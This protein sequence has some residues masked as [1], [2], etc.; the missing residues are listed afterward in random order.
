MNTEEQEIV[1]EKL[2]KFL[3]EQ[4]QTQT[5][6]LS[7][8]KIKSLENLI[9]NF[10]ELKCLFLNN[11]YISI[12]PK[13]FGSLT[14]LLLL[15]LDN[16][17]LKSLPEQIGELSLLNKLSICNNQLTTLTPRIGKLSN[18]EELYLT[19]NHLKFIPKELG[20]LK[21]LSKLDLGGNQIGE[22]PQSFGNLTELTDLALSFNSLQILPIEIC[23]LIKL[24]QLYLNDNQL[25]DLPENFG[26]LI[27]VKELELSN[28]L[29]T[30]IP[31]QLFNLVQL[32]SFYVVNNKLENIP[33]EIGLLRSLSI[34]CLDSNK[35]L[36]IP[37][38]IGNLSN[39]RSLR[40]NENRLINLP[41]EIG[42]CSNLIDLEL[43]HNRIEEL[44]NSI[45]NLLNLKRLI[46]TENRIS[47]L[48][49]ELSLLK[50]LS[51]FDIS[52]NLIDIIPEEYQNIHSLKN[53]RR[54]FT[55]FNLSRSS[56]KSSSSYTFSEKIIND[57]HYN[58]Q[59]NSI[60][61]NFKTNFQEKS[62]QKNLV[63][64][65]PSQNLKKIDDNPQ[66]TI[67][68]I[69]TK[70]TNPDLSE[71]HSTQTLTEIFGKSL[72]DPNLLN[73]TFNNENNNN[74]NNENNNNNNFGGDSLF[75]LLNENEYQYSTHFHS[76]E[77]FETIIENL[78]NN[79]ENFKQFVTNHFEKLSKNPFQRIQ[80]PMIKM[81]EK[82]RNLHPPTIQ[83]EIKLL[84]AYNIINELE[85]VTK[86]VA[87]SRKE[88]I[89]RIYHLE[90]KLKEN[91]EE[92]QQ[93]RMQ[94]HTIENQ[95]GFEDN[96]NEVDLSEFEL[97]E[98]IGKGSFGKVFRAIWRG[99]EVAV[100]QI[101]EEYHVGKYLSEFKREALIL[102]RMRHPNI[103]LFMAASTKPPN[104]FLVTEY[105]KEGSLYHSLQKKT[106]PNS[107]QIRIKIAKDI[108]LGLNYLHLTKPKPVIHR[109]LKSLNVLLDQHQNAKVADFGMSKIKEH[110]LE[111]SKFRGTPCWM[112]PE[113]FRCE[114]YSEKVDIYSYGVVLWELIT[115]K[116][117]YRQV[118]DPIQLGIQV[119][120][121]NLRPDLDQI[122]DEN[123]KNL[124][125][126]CWA[127][128]PNDRP[129]SNE[130]I[131][132]LDSFPK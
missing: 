55:L 90:E 66:T 11:N 50:N 124:I 121:Q 10:E 91:K 27:N 14:S 81:N 54:S 28:N 82:E 1:K 109:D 18:L 23:N 119:G 118:T 21:K 20:S 120:F 47:S 15:N 117:P 17:S 67:S 63:W 99:K 49:K 103:V 24:E 25:S 108:A 88:A 79:N 73:F 12:L 116:V 62:N 87:N 96:Y 129:S 125:L 5:L 40:A 8:L 111:L 69:S 105:L 89:R 38:S 19:D 75:H 35:L 85:K 94:L 30:K 33:E 31:H 58:Q 60:I 80:I 132:I 45:G 110:S 43:Y 126:K 83:L 36:N 131:Q 16:N 32:N 29:F 115:R 7:K 86:K 71:V 127:N 107:E 74:E 46:L 59:I 42:N 70:S 6:D 37:H 26:N 104:V 9:I 78:R 84:E 100:K 2:E 112:A 13:E 123:W 101:F 95:I 22:L 98:E 114:K 128:N 56:S 122:K 77:D 51:D 130:I 97:K 106:F 113:I 52:E 41:I 53:P 102:S 61:S 4:K 3:N 64:I 39:L 68:T 57:E 65:F 44:P 48:P 34:F 76:E 72:L 92:L 93:L